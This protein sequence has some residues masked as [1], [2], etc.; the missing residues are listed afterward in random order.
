MS[1]VSADITINFIL[2]LRYLQKASKRQIY[3]MVETVCN[4]DFTPVITSL[5]RPKWLR[6]RPDG[7]ATF[8]LLV[9]S[10]LR[11]IDNTSDDD[12][13]HRYYAGVSPPVFISGFGGSSMTAFS[14]F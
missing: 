10:T 2:L 3:F 1:V 14:V 8:F 12:V 13:E 9:P 6:F 7:T 4:V 5:S 11:N